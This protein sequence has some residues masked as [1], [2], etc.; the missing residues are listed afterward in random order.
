MC[1][2]LVGAACS[3]L[4]GLLLTNYSLSLILTLYRLPS[5]HGEGVSIIRYLIPSIFSLF[6][7]PL[8][9]SGG[10]V[11][12][13]SSFGAWTQSGDG[14]PLGLPGPASHSVP[15]HTRPS[16]VHMAVQPRYSRAPPRLPR[17][18]AHAPS[19]GAAAA[20]C[21]RKH[22]AKAVPKQYQSVT[23]KVKVTCRYQNLYSA[24]QI[25]DTCTSNTTALGTSKEDDF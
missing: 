2:Y 12:T 6:F 9:L 15:V 20:L 21:A 13:G 7:F 16:L 5:Q 23:A 19:R 17:G 22:T 25:Y 18:A 11:P 3:V 1:I 4:L 8:R 10:G 24:N 14:R